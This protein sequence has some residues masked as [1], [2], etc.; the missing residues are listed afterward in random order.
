MLEFEDSDCFIKEYFR[1]LRLD[2]MEPLPIIQGSE[3]LFC[4][5]NIQAMQNRSFFITEKGRMGIGPRSIRPSDL[6]TII[7]GASMPLIL[8]K[9]ETHYISNPYIDGENGTSTRYI[10]VGPTYT[11]GL[12]SGEGV[13]IPII[14]NVPDQEIPGVN[15]ILAPARAR[16]YSLL[17]LNFANGKRV[18]YTYPWD[19]F[20]LV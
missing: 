19:I 18:Q 6:V 1:R 13:P 15:D 8:R 10:V 17:G 4:T 14:R 3:M 7:S 20:D 11:H 16:L 2:I 5:A 12:M 9:I